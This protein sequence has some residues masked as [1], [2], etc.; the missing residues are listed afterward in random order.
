MRIT[1]PKFKSHVITTQNWEALV[2][3]TQTTQLDWQ[4]RGLF[5]KYCT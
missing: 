2:K 4:T 5:T 3:N 1:N